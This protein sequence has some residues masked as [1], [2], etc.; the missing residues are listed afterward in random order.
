MRICSMSNRAIDDSAQDRI[1]PES[2]RA[3]RQLVN[4]HG[5]GRVQ[6]SLMEIAEE[7]A[8]ENDG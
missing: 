3:L 5:L 7:Q 4:M 6:R 1:D 8:K 2:K